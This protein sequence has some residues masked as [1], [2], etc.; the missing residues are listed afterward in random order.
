MKERRILGEAAEFYTLNPALDHC[1]RE[2]A[3]TQGQEKN[4]EPVFPK[5]L[6]GSVC[7]PSAQSETRKCCSG[8]NFTVLFLVQLTCL[9]LLAHVGI[10]C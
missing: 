6:P 2:E 5:V 10:N 4:L 7:I 9:L 3:V 8:L 1:N